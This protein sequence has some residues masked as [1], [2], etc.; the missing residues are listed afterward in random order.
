M[1]MA[2]TA[3][4]RVEMVERSETASNVSTATN[5]DITRVIADHHERENMPIQPKQTTIEAILPLQQLQ[6][7]AMMQAAGISILERQPT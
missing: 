7:H 3:K 5:W 2:R 4:R 1:E 6:R